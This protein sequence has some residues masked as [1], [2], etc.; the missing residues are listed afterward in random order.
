MNADQ[1]SQFTSAE[2]IGT[3][4]R[5]NIAISSDSTGCWRPTRC[6]MTAKATTH[7]EADLH[8]HYAMAASKESPTHPHSNGRPT[9]PDAAYFG[10]SPLAAAA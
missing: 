9:G 7:E 1:G 10:Q 8:A 6:S 5:H 3:L 2:F 4:E